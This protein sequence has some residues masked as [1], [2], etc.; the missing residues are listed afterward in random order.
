MHWRGIA[1]TLPFNNVKIYGA[2]EGSN[3][4]AGTGKEAEARSS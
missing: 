3:Y 1:G 4:S 2:K